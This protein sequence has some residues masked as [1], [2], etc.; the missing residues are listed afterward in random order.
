M[1]AN[2]QRSIATVWDLNSRLWESVI[3]LPEDVR[4]TV[5]CNSRYAV[6]ATNETGRLC[7]LD[8]Q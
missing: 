7:V 2:T 4:E 3:V 1:E 8:W 6:F 5:A